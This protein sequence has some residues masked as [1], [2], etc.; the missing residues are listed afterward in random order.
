VR[1]SR[2]PPGAPSAESLTTKRWIDEVGRRPSLCPSFDSEGA[3]GSAGVAAPVSV[4]LLDCELAVSR[5]SVGGAPT[6][7][8]AL[9][10]ASLAA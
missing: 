7:T 5:T 8:W 3:R 1:P 10:A 2:P 4:G 6:Y 9:L